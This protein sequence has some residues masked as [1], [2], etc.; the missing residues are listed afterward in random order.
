MS[1]WGRQ[2]DIP[3]CP[4]KGE[5]VAFLLVKDCYV[6]GEVTRIL[7]NQPGRWK[8]EIEVKKQ[9]GTLQKNYIGGLLMFEHTYLAETF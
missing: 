1:D 8:V 4:E 9:K 7:Y 3:K 5:E 2:F 6:Q